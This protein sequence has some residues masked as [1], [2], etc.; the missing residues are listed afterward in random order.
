[1]LSYSKGTV[2]TTE[3]NVLSVSTDGG[4]CSSC[5]DSFLGLNEAVWLD[6]CW[7]CAHIDRIS[8]DITA[9][10]A[11]LQHSKVQYTLTNEV[12]T[13]QSVIST[14][15]KFEIQGST[16]GYAFFTTTLSDSAAKITV[17]VTEGPTVNVQI[18]PVD[19][20]LR[21][22]PYSRTIVCP[23]GFL[24]EVYNSKGNTKYLVG[25]F[26]IV[27]TGEDVKGTITVATGDQVCTSMD[28]SI[29]PFCGGYGYSVI[30]D[31]ET[32]SQKDSYARNFYNQ[33]LNS[34]NAA[35]TGTCTQ[36]RNDEDN[37]KLFACQYAVPRCLEGFA[38]PPEYS[39][40][41]DVEKEWGVTFLAA[42]YAKL[43]CDHNF[44]DGGI[45]WVGPGDDDIQIP[46]SDTTTEETPPNLLYLLFLLLLLL[47]III[48]VVVV[49][50]KQDDGGGGVPSSASQTSS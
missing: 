33:L 38:L 30:G 14:E 49:Y 40:C 2:T 10:D 39:V 12:V 9:G 37:L 3:T 16:L 45:I 1:V 5:S 17:K 47:I 23:R 48:V 19:C 27:I 29:A 13:W 25:D 43:S 44:Y 8:V 11:Y 32:V 50:L 42:G 31:K 22:A 34:F 46:P 41:V 21:V 18:F 24:C 28:T 35:I 6:S 20:S 36:Q 7:H 4:S 15:A 26:R